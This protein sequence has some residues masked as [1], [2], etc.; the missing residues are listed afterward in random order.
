LSECYES[1]RDSTALGR[2]SDDELLPT[3]DNYHLLLV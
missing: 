1:L 2:G 3:Q